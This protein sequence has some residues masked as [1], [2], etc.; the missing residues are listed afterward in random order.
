MVANRLIGWGDRQEID[1]KFYVKFIIYL[2][3][4][5]IPTMNIHLISE[6]AGSS[7]G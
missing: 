7:V 4:V 1:N 2:A 6:R 5:T 3:M